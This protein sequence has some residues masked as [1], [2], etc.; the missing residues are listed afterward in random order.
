MSDVLI[1]RALVLLNAVLSIFIENYE[2]PNI[3]LS[4]LQRFAWKLASINEAC[5]VLFNEIQMLRP[6][7]VGYWW[8]NGYKASVE[9]YWQ[10][11]LGEKPAPVPYMS[12]TNLT[13][14]DQVSNPG[15]RGDRPATNRLSHGTALSTLLPRDA[16]LLAVTTDH[17]MDDFQN[18]LRFFARIP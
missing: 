17:V 2:L 5:S 9:W 8:V 16:V 4:T 14:A 12:T 18:F 13:W 10:E 11:T 15:L 3:M 7:T 1:K 6:G